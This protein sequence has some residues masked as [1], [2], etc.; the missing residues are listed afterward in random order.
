MIETH[1]MI[2]QIYIRMILLM[3]G[4]SKVPIA[5]HPCISSSGV[6][7]TLFCKVKLLI[8]SNLCLHVPAVAHISNHSSCSCCL[9]QRFSCYLMSALNM[10]EISHL[11]F[12]NCLISAIRLLKLLCNNSITSIEIRSFNMFNAELCIFTTEK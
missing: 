8:A 12:Y 11:L 5:Q 3:P 2:Q 9:S 1:A 6:R 10:P 4:K 7:R